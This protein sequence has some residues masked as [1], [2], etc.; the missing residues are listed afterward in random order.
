M[1]P[2]CK[3]TTNLWFN[4]FWLNFHAA[5]ANKNAISWPRYML[6]LTYIVHSTH[7]GVD[8]R[9][10]EEEGEA[11][12]QQQGS[13]AV[14]GGAEGPGPH[15]V[16]DHDVSKHHLNIKSF[17]KKTMSILILL[18]QNLLYIPSFWWKVF[19]CFC[20]LLIILFVRYTETETVHDVNWKHTRCI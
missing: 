9:Q 11:P 15:R 6:T 3:I 8:H 2:W 5:F 17:L 13:P 4:L 12:D 7:I 20:K 16:H 18:K 14:G 10:G 19:L 1:S